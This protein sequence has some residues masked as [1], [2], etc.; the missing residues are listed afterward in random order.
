MERRSRWRRSQ[1]LNRAVPFGLVVALGWA[2]VPLTTDEIDT[3]VLAIAGAVTIVLVGAVILV[4]W[5]RLPRS[6]ALIP[7]FGSVLI[8]ALLREASGGG[9][10][11][12]GVLVLAPVVWLALY[13]SRGALIALLIWIAVALTL[14]IVIVGAPEYP[15]SDWRRALLITAMGAV[16]GLTTQQLVNEVRAR[17]KREQQRESYIRAVMDSASEG[18]VAIDTNGIVN[19]ANRSAAELTGYSVDG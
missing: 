4:P 8:V 19:F 13:A 14:P 5:S 18:I 7:P 2:T 11:G 17:A 1:L 15:E 3:T 12:Y 6:W 9:A 10:S 16:I